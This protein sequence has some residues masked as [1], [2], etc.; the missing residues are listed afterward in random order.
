MAAISSA[1]LEATAVRKNGYAPKQG[2]GIVVPKSLANCQNICA[3]NL[4]GVVK[5]GGGNVGCLGGSYGR[6]RLKELLPSVYRDAGCGASEVG[7]V[8]SQGTETLVDDP[9]ELGA[10]SAVLRE[11]RRPGNTAPGRAA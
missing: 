7:Y 2:T 1:L 8:A 10:L 6:A 11:G 5:G 4:S 9:I 3:V